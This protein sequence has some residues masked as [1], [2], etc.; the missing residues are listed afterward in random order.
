MKESSAA[1]IDIH[2]MRPEVFRNLLRFVYTE[3]LPP[4]TEEEQDEAAMTQHLLEAADR[5]GME[6]LKLLCEDRLCEHINVSTVVTTLVLAEQHGCPGLK[7][8]CFQFLLDSNSTTLEAVMATDDFDNILSNSCPNLLKELMSRLASSASLHDWQIIDRLEEEDDLTLC[9]TEGGELPE[10][11]HGI[12]P[13][14]ARAPKR[15]RL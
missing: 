7:E 3:E 4:V 14:G 5:Y 12:L 6:R 15:M 1:G 10:P 2:G 11:A 9:T 8:A 13:L